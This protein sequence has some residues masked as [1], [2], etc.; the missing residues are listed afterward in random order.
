VIAA[1]D[2][3]GPFYANYTAT[4][5]NDLYFANNS[6]SGG[7]TQYHKA[8]NIGTGAVSDITLTNNEYCACGYEGVAVSDG[9]SI[10]YFANGGVRWTPGDA[11]W[12]GVTGYAGS[13][14]YDGESATA[15]VKG[16]VYRISGRAYPDRVSYFDTSGGT[17]VTDGLTEHPD[18]GATYRR[19]AGAAN[20]NIY[21]FGWAQVVSEYNTTTN[22][23]HT[24]AVDP[25]APTSCSGVNVHL[26]GNHLVYANGREIKRFNADTL[27]WE[28]ADI[29]L[30]DTENLTGHRAMVADGRLFALGYHTADK[31]VQIFEYRLGG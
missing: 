21:V 9:S 15:V 18:A 24:T 22:E 7:I 25:N 28:E 2:V 8:F 27:R 31:Q 4:I 19:C 6:N 14:F 5:G 29:P 30:P 12:T 13:E 11:S 1:I 23:W 16:R 20:G 17:F 26:W 10:F 3:S